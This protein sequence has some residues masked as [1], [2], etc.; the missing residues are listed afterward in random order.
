M[1]IVAAIWFR[2]VKLFI[3]NRVQLVLML[4]MPFFYLYLLSSAFASTSITNPLHYVLA[5]IVIIVVFQTSLNIATSTIEDIV[6]GYMKEVLVSPV[7]RIQIAAGQMLASATI[8]TFQGIMILIIG[9]CIGMTYA[10]ILT[11]FA[12]IGFM[13]LVGLVFSAFGLFLATLAKNSQTFQIVSVAVT[14]PFTFLCG[15]YIPLSLLP[16]GLQYMALFNPMTYAAAFFRALSLEKM[17]LPPDELVAEQ[18]AFKVSD[19]VITPQLGI[20]FIISFG[21]LFLLLSTIAFAKV[22]FSRM[23]RAQGT[24]DI[25]QQ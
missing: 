22:D 21:I 13:I 8:A 1:R 7:K 4:I 3:R 17:S 20:I 2:N 12:I 16:D 14:T 9:Y 10:S 6:S 25:F 11:P 15:V 19:F 18:L 24:K 5:G 23:N